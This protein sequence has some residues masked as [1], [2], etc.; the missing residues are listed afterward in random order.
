MD[1]T[2]ENKRKNRGCDELLVE[3]HVL[4]RLAVIGRSKSGLTS[5]STIDTGVGTSNLLHCYE[6]Q[7]GPSSLRFHK[8]MK[9]AESL[10]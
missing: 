5:R 10:R 8:R 4:G 1:S 3:N 9:N 7:N 6:R 2:N